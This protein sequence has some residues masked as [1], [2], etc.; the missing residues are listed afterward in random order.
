MCLRRSHGRLLTSALRARA[1]SL[2]SM[3]AQVYISYVRCVQ[4]IPKPSFRNRLTIYARPEL[5]GPGDG[6]EARHVMLPGSAL[7]VSVSDSTN[8]RGIS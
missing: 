8:G 2:L 5:S 4:R 7:S 1:R 3:Y 6:G